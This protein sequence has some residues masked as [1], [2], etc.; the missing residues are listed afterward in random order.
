MGMDP[1]FCFPI[2]AG[3]RLFDGRGI[4]HPAYP[5]AGDG[6]EDRLGLAIGGIPAV[7]VAAYIV[8]EMP[9]DLSAL[10]GH[11]LVVFYAA[12]VMAHASAKGR[13]EGRAEGGTAPLAAEAEA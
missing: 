4:E 6:F 2:M 13:R 11:H 12:A 9:I 5:D 10:A 3:G 7:L 8:K 1:H